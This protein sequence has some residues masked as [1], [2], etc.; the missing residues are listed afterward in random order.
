MEKTTGETPVLQMTTTVLP[1][2][3]IDPVESAAARVP[4]PSES[5]WAPA[6]RSRRAVFGGGILT[7]IVLFCLATL[8]I[9]APRSSSFWFDKQDSTLSRTPPKAWPPQAW[10]G[11]DGLGRS[12]FAR[13]L[14]GGTISLGVGIAAAGISVVLGVAVGLIAGYRGGLTDAALMRS[15]DVL[16]GLPYILLVIL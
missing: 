7:V 6:M 5:I 8:V 11:Y 14:L 9:T 13:C 1:E 16:Y 4:E 10:Y 3:R 12:I 2:P 15:V